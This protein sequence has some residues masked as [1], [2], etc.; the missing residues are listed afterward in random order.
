MLSSHDLEIRG[1]GELLGDGQSGQI[2]EV[3]FSLYTALLEKAV[4]ALK[5]GKQPELDFSLDAG[6][7][8]NLQTPAL[9]PND[10]LPDIHARLVLYKRIANTETFDELHALK[11]EMID[12]FG[13]FPDAVK[14]LFFVS[15][16]KQ[17]AN[18]LSLKK[19]EF[20]QV[21]GR[22]VFGDNP[23]I[24]TEELIK[25][26][27]TQ[28][29]CYQLKGIEQLNIIKKFANLEEK[30]AFIKQLLQQLSHV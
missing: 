9:I 25:L 17:Q 18:H 3:G 22:I 15:E 5:S 7:D 27:Q 12:R 11:I 16:I 24:N 26:V 6:I 21:G 30:V 8:V 2:Q 23:K 10:Y 1:A 28:P 19:I 4:S 13:L 20:S 14:A 29:Q